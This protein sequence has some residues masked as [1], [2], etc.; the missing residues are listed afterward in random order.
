MTLI[1]NSTPNSTPTPPPSP[2]SAKRPLPG[3]THDNRAFWTGGES[4]QLLI[5]RCGACGRFQHPPRPM[6]TSCGGRAV[7]PTPVS[8]KGKVMTMT[9]N[10]QKWLPNLDVPYVF[11]AVELAE[12]EGLYVLTNV[13]KCDAEKVHIGMKVKAF[14]EHI[15][16]I[17]FPLFEPDA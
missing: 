11:A 8:G 12:Q 10:H 3:L 1:P 17:Y 13:T 15:D 9:I 16:D 14:F 2:T 7:Q 5:Q 4:G 6:C